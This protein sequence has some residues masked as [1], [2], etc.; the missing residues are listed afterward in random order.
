MLPNYVAFIKYHIQVGWHLTTWANTW[1]QVFAQVAASYLAHLA[2]KNQTCHGFGQTLSPPI[3]TM[4]GARSGRGSHPAK[5]LLLPRIF[6]NPSEN[7]CPPRPKTKKN[8]ALTF[9]KAASLQIPYW[10]HFVFKGLKSNIYVHFH[11]VN[12]PSI[13]I[14]FWKWNHHWKCN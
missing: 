6:S 3:R 4:G 11:V 13:G 8:I 14:S 12:K 2:H 10:V 5:F 7:S 1:Y 9:L